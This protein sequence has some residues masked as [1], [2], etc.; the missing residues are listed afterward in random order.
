MQAFFRSRLWN[1]ADSQ[2]LTQEVA[3]RALPRLRE[4]AAPAEVRSYLF[5]TARS[6]L[7]EFWSERL[8]HPT[9]G[10]RDDA[11]SLP[12][13]EPPAGPELRVRVLLSGL[14]AD[15]RQV[16]ELRFLH[17]FSLREAAAEMGRTPGAIKQL[18]LRALRAAAGT[19]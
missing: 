15:H 13:A 16:L 19:S 14:A 4:G 10:L 5:R 1:L 7:A 6:V 8:G 2:D 17:G 3:L 18:Q 12:L 9:V 11:P